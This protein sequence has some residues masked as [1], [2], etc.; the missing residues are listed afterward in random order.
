M[1]TPSELEGLR[2]LGAGASIESVCQALGMPVDAFHQWWTQIAQRRA[3]A[4]H[5][6]VTAP[7]GADVRIARDLHGIPHVLAENDWDL[8]FGFGW[9]IAEDRLFQLDWLRRKAT[10][11]LSEIVGCEGLESDRLV[12]TIGLSHIATAEWAQLTDPVRSLLHAFTAGIN[13]WIDQNEDRMPIEFDLLDYRPERW[14]EIDCVAIENEFRWYLTGRF[15]VI[16]IPEIARRSL[17][18]GPLLAEFLR[19]E[20]DEE[21][22]LHDG[23]FVP[24]DELSPERVGEV[25]VDPDGGVGS[26]NWALSGRRT[27]SGMPLVASDPHIA[28]GAV[29]CWYEVHLCGGSFNV[30]GTCY[31]GVPAVMI[32]R[33]QQVA[34]G[35]TNNICSLRDLYREQTDAEH[36]GCFLFDGVWE[37]WRERSE[38]ISIR[39]A[40]PHQQTVRL[41]RNGPLVDELLPAPA[42]QHGPVSLKWLGTHHGGWLTGMLAMNRAT[43]VPTFRQALRPWYVPTFSMVFAD[44]VGQIGFQTSGRIPLRQQAQ[45]GFRR[46]WDPADQ[47]QGLLPFETMPQITDPD[48]GWIASANNR[49]A[50]PDF[51]FPLAGTWTSGW[52]G[53][54]IREMIEA[55][56]H[57]G[58]ADSGKMQ[59]DSVDLRAAAVVPGLLL[60][61]E[62]VSEPR[63]AQAADLLAKWD[64]RAEADSVPAAIFNL[65]F[66][67][68]C[69]EVAGAR[70]DDESRDLLQQGVGGCA[71]RL[72]TADPL[73]WFVNGDRESRIRQTFQATLDFL[74]SECGTDMS[75]WTWGHFHRLDLC[76]VLSQR[77][78]LA[79]LLDHGGVGVRGDMQTVGNTGSGHR[80]TA[81]TGGGYR[82]IADLGASPPRLLAVDAQGQSGRPTNPCYDDQL[83]D[84]LQG[85]YHEIPLD[86]E[87]VG[88]LCDHV[89]R[90]ARGAR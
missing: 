89:F 6:Q 40:E 15:P 76:H 83:S 35:I 3:L 62:S 82:M 16:C 36:P 61:L 72:L 17:G 38:T 59:L 7:V 47:W 4:T 34:W 66:S 25:I 84:W 80:W 60:V 2:R 73:G 9:A 70:F 46:G 12:R 77:G 75:D 24:A 64:F 51:P 74:G 86:P 27:T 71:A 50:P 56:S 87:E 44:T 21:S 85:K 30:A 19:G 45:R 22:I 53:Q 42:N 10:G 79:T 49:L 67:H 65:F 78:A 52:R 63:F 32:G 33:N 43:D 31:A 23:D 88:R 5:E 14:R 8:F 48:R 11:R 68:W 37:P 26:N 55:R 90:L 28:F 81:A 18:D 20:C 13:D 58:P 54:R 41:S 1:S 57:L 39:N 69:E 29:S